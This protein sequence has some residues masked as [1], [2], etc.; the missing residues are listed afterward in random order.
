[1]TELD[2]NDA[3]ADSAPEGEAQP[4]VFVYRI[5]QRKG[6]PTLRGEI[7]ADDE[8]DAERQLRLKLL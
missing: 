3:P 1:M 8:A 4:K 6:L 5:Q 7:L 2:A